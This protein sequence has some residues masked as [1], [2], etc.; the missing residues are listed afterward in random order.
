MYNFTEIF[1]DRNRFFYR[2]I[3][4]KSVDI[5]KGNCPQRKSTRYLKTDIKK[6]KIVN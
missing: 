3:I 5:S 6:K 1:F 4:Y 2:N